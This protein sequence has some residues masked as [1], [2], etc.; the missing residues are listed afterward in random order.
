[1]S[2]FR[3]SLVAGRRWIIRALS[4]SRC[5][6]CTVVAMAAA[7]TV[8]AQPS[9]PHIRIDQFGYSPQAKKIAVL[10]EPVQGFDAP[11]PFSPGPLIEVRR[12]SDQQVAFSAE[13][14]TWNAGAV[15]AQ[16]GDRV[17]RVDFSA[18]SAPGTYYIHDPTTGA[19]SEPFDIRDDVY[20]LALRQ[21]VRMYYYQRCGTPKAVPFTPA[22]WSDATCHLGS[23]QDLDCRFVLDPVPSTSRDLSGGWHD[24]G[25]YGKYVNYADKALHSL[26]FAYQDAPWYWQD[27]YGIPE[28]GNGVPDLLDEIK[29]EL[30]WLLKMQNSDGSVLYRMDVTDYSHASPPSMDGGPRRYGP[31]TASATINACGAY[32]HAALVFA[33]LP[34]TQAYAATLQTAA[35]NAWNWLV[36]HPEAIPSA[37]N[38]AGFASVVP[39]ESAYDQ[40]TSRLCAAIYLFRLT[41]MASY[42]SY[43]DANYLSA[44]L[45]VWTYASVFEQEYNDALLL[46]AAS[47]GATPTVAATIAY[48]YSDSALVDHLV[49]V[50]NLVD[51]FGAFLEDQ[52]HGWGCNRIRALQGQMYASMSR[53]CLGGA[54]TPA[55][56]NAAEAYVHFFHGV[57]PL[58][59]VFLT[60]MGAFGAQ[61]SVNETFHYWFFH[62]TIWDNAATSPFGPAP[63]YL[64]G[65]PNPLYAPDA[66]YTGPPIQPPQ[67][68]PIQKSYRDWNSPWPQNSWSVTEGA[69]AY[70]A[71]YVRLLANIAAGAASCLGDVNRDGRLDGRD[72]G[73]FV[74]C[75]L[76]SGANCRCADVDGSGSTTINDIPLFAAQLLTLPVCQ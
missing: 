75:I 38:N 47:P 22:G 15:H 25:N 32:A 23:Q 40:Q 12:A 24:A 16:S 1:M 3:I 7:E 72:I 50:Q 8:Q 54:N 41:G 49:Y 42:R 30:D 14:L 66:S 10:R 60:N 2:S 29:W 28:S 53:N 11:L 17:W 18:L 13:P 52:F 46:Y 63:G 21:A 55:L 48:W 39:D 64:T 69:I 65:G 34:Q 35:V 27:D 6:L 67:N 19:S 59:L 73:G 74:D 36:A 71:A 43:V 61:S 45:F 51:P 9:S 62:G 26:L 4:M 5:A 20:D 56:R 70:Q 57:N 37:Y 76:G 58:G 33:S 31:A 68:Q 44:H